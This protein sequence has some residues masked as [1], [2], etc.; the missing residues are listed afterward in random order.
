MHKACN[1]PR[2]RCCCGASLG[3]RASVAFDS[4]DR[5]CLGTSG[6]KAVK[7]LAPTK[8]QQPTPEKSTAWCTESDLSDREV[9]YYVAAYCSFPSAFGTGEHALQ[10][11]GDLMPHHELLQGFLTSL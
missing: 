8:R 1:P 4:R 10:N 2:S 6:T 5:L 3:G 7:P 9:H 11:P